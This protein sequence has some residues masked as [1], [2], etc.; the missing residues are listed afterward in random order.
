[1]SNV[2]RI[3]SPHPGAAWRPLALVAW[4]AAP[5][6]LGLLIGRISSPDAWYAA[7]AKPSWNPPSWVFGPVWTALYG[8]M[9]LAAYLVWRQLG[10]R[11]G[12]VPLGL[13]GA[14]LLV[15]LAW[16]PIFFGLHQLGWALADIIVM[17]ALIV[18]TTAAFWRV[19]R[20]A[21]VLMLPY[22]A[23]VSF[24]MTLNAEIW[25]LNP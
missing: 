2:A 16:S 6:V 5:I 8:A 22:V 15:N 25:R 23:W 14:Q 7:L 12:R 17:L 1:M 11:G 18:A 19:N 3:D 21:G 13:F 20:W 4:I 9:G 10:W 24:A